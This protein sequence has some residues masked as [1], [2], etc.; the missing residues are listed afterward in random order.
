[1]KKTIYFVISSLGEDFLV[2]YFYILLFG[3]I[4]F[5]ILPGIATIILLLFCVIPMLM[6]FIFFSFCS[7]ISSIIALFEKKVNFALLLLFFVAA[8]VSYTTYF[9]VELHF[10]TCNFVYKGFF[11]RNDFQKIRVAL[12]QYRQKHNEYPPTHIGLKTLPDY[13]KISEDPWGDP[14]YYEKKEQSYILKCIN[15]DSVYPRKRHD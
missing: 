3:I 8:P 9:A 11:V 5:V 15:A 4:A 2:Y 14:Y 12:E 1:M 13:L 7:V 6:F 10:Y